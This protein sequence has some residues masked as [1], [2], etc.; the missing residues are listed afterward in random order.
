MRRPRGCGGRF[1][2]TKTSKGAKFGN[3]PEK[4]GN[5]HHFQ[6]AESQISEVLQSD[7]GNLSSP[8]EASGSRTN[9]SGSEVTSLFYRGEVDHFA[10]NH[11]RPSVLSL[12]DM[13]NTGPGRAMPNLEVVEVDVI[14]VSIS[15]LDIALASGVM[16]CKI[17]D[18]ICCPVMPYKCGVHVCDLEV[19]EVSIL[20]SNF[21]PLVK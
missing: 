12:T 15:S 10:F 18:L 20:S 7:S 1:L 8:K 9:L 11:L 14:E 19:V 4:T 6:P 17:V 5:G 21:E 13:M 16:Y 3:E 2:N